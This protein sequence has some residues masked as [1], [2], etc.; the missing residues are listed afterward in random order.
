M[1]L[2]LIEL[3]G[4][5]RSFSYWRKDSAARRLA[6]DTSWLA[7]AIADANLIHLSGITVAILE[8]TARHRLIALQRTG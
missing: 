8:T 1:G 4:V 7:N 3:D 5:E 2:Y 6:D